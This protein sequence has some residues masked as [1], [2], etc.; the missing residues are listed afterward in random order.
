MK[1]TAKT[2]LIRTGFALLPWLPVFLVVASLTPKQYYTRVVIDL[3]EPLATL[4][5]GTAFHL[6]ALPPIGYLGLATALAFV[7]GVALLL[8]GSLSRSHDG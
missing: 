4:H 8:I 6:S 3:N 7:A 2:K 1:S 5:H